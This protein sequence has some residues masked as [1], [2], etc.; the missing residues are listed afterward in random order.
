MPLP[1]EGP[2]LIVICSHLSGELQLPQVLTQSARYLRLPFPDDFRQQDVGRLW[3]TQRDRPV[4]DDTSGPEVDVVSVALAGG[5]GRLLLERAAVARSRD[6][7]GDIDRATVRVDIGECGGEVGI[8]TG[9]SGET[10]PPEELAGTT[11]RSPSEISLPA[12]L[13]RRARP[14]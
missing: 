11:D 3:A 1:G 13:W 7:V 14:R 2:G 8:P 9:R 12:S 6:A 4:E 10:D 5:D